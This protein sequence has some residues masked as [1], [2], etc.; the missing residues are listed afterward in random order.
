MTRH[1]ENGPQGEGTQG[2]TGSDTTKE[3]YYYLEYTVIFFMK[4]EL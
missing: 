1:T 4:Y 2:F 3:K